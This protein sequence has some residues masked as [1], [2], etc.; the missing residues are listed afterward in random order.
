MTVYFDNGSTSFPKAPNVA[1]AVGEL[2]K[3]GS[4]N[5][6]RGIYKEASSLAE[7]VFSTRERLCRLFNFEN[8][9]NVIFT[10][11]ITY[12]L[13]MVIRGFLRPGDHVIVSSMEHNAMMR[14]LFQLSRYGVEF[15]VAEAD[16]E[17]VLAPE[18]IEELIKP[19]TKAVMMLT[20][21]NVCGTMLPIEEAGEICRRRGLKFVVDSAQTAGA[22]PIDM[23]KMNIDAL[24]FTGHKSLRG[25]QG[26]GG[27]VVKDEMAS[28]IEPI[29]AGGTGSISDSE[30][31]PQFLPDKFEAGTMNI[32]GIV[33]LNEALI[34]L[35]KVGLEETAKKELFITE[36][37]LNKA[38]SIPEVNVTGK[39]DM[40][41]RAPIVSLT[42]NTMDNAEAAF[43]LENNYGIMTRCGLHCAP[44]AHKTL[45]TFPEGT[46]RFSFSP[47][48]TEE[49]VDYTINAI[50]EIVR[51]KRD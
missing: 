7:K 32:P 45:G 36:R 24:C 34:Y 23:E 42:F 9:S 14:P 37:F 21:S 22:F 33:G 16:R 8:P 10:N 1:E 39:K 49:E 44:R 41:G 3:E 35:E 6:N 30:E 46:V 43:L 20:A 38:L 4:F 50:N 27:F 2:L 17:G 28:L 5:I 13:N 26:I 25:P 51:G 15:S 11:N 48:N 18:K 19:N 40:K 12:A 47:F 31:I 29:I